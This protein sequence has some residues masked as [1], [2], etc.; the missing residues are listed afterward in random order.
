MAI[1]F[2]LLD[3]EGGHPLSY[4]ERQWGHHALSSC[5]LLFPQEA[6]ILSLRPEARDGHPIHFSKRWGLT[7]LSLLPP[8]SVLLAFVLQRQGV[9]ILYLD[10]GEARGG[11]NFSYSSLVFSPLF[12]DRL[13]LSF[14]RDKQ[15]M[16]IH[17]LSEARRGVP[18]LS[19]LRERQGV[20]SSL[21][22]IISVF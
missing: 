4:L 5:P 22:F 3:R 7:I 9:A 1:L 20:R 21:F 17:S 16:A 12:P 6:A 14:L 18:I 11:R 8:F 15:E 10:S 2:I 13:S 19:L